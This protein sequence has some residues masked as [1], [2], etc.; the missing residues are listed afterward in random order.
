MI[1]LLASNITEN[2]FWWWR[3]RMEASSALLV[4]CVGNSSV[5]GEFL[6]RRPVTRSFEIYLSAPE[7]TA[8]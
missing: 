2:W 7:Q 8:E 6:S 1:G 3:H 5:T 4:L